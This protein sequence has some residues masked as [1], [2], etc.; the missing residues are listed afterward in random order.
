MPAPTLAGVITGK[1]KARRARVA[2]DMPGSKG[3]NV[4][5]GLEL[6]VLKA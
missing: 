2:A 4:E 6:G 5:E 1:V 3:F